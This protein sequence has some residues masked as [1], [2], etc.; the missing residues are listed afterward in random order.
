MCSSGLF[1]TYSVEILPYGIRAKGTTLANFVTLVA[2][3]FNQYVNSIA[4]DALQWRYYIFYCAFLA[5]EVFVIYFFIIET[6]YTPIE[7]VTRFF[8]GDKAD[9]IE[10]TNAQTEKEAEVGD[11]QQKEDAGR[12]TV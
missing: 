1:T 9:V 5:L 2:V 10:I 11:V 12:G 3:F 8:D 4:L 6:R 7:E